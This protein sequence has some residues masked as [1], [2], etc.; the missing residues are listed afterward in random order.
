[1]KIYLVEKWRQMTDDDDCCHCAI[2]ELGY[3]RHYLKAL[4]VA[5]NNGELDKDVFVQTIEVNESEQ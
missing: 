1:M 3:Y 4:E 2:V 5:N